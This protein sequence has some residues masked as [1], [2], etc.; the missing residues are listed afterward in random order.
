MKDASTQQRTNYASHNTYNIILF[1]SSFVGLTCNYCESV[2]CI[3]CE[4]WGK[5]VQILLIENVN[6]SKI[7]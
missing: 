6:K 1:L 3:L 4:E 2:G 7:M 5:I